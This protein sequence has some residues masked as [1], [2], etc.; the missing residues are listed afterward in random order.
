MKELNRQGFA[1]YSD[2]RLPT[3]EEAI[4]LMEREE[5]NGLYIDP[6]FDSRQWRIWTAD[7]ESASRA[8]VVLFD[9]GY[10]N[11]RDLYHGYD[12]FVRAV[13]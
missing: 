4:S 8:W 7:K 10:C 13:R 9:L 2:W 12:V 6:L 3:L 5:K 1:G 11:R